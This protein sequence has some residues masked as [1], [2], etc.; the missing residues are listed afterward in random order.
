MVLLVATAVH[1]FTPRSPF[2]NPRRFCTQLAAEEEE[3]SSAS[4]AAAGPTPAPAYDPDNLID[5]NDSKVMS[6]IIRSWDKVEGEDAVAVTELLKDSAELA[7]MDAVDKYGRCALSIAAEMGKTGI[8][9]ALL[10]AGA[11]PNTR[12]EN[13][14][15]PV[16]VASSYG[17]IDTV[18]ALIENGGDVN[19]A[20]ELLLWWTKE[21]KVTPLKRA[22]DQGH[23]DIAAYLEGKGAKMEV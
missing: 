8:V 18:K 22:K 20:A 11:N 17:K 15:T 5:A 10:A 6:Y 7:N 1:A 23:K 19:A 14:I 12:M 4:P 3:G 21:V 13:N 2:L 9:E 16:Y